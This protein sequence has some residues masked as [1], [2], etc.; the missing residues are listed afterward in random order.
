MKKSKQAFT[1]LKRFCLRLK[2]TPVLVT[3]M[4]LISSVAFA[5]STSAVRGDV[6]D[7]N[8]KPVAAASVSLYREIDNVLVKA[9]FTNPQ[10]IYSFDGIKANTYLLKITSTG[11]RQATVSIQVTGEGDIKV[12]A[13]I[14]RIEEKKLAGVTVQAQKPLFENKA[15]KIVVNVSASP[16]NAGANALEVLE[17]SPG[18][19]VDKDGNISLK[20]KAGVQVF[21]DGKPAYL[22]G[23]DL[24]NFLKNLQGT[25]L[26]QVE[27][28]TNPSARFDAA[29]NSGIINI[30]TKKTI[31]LGYS[32]TFTA[33][34][35]QGI[36]ARNNQD[37]TFNYRKNKVN[38]FGTFSRNERNT[39]RTFIIDRKFIDPTTKEV[40][41]L[42]SQESDKKNWNASNSIKLG[43][44]LFATKRTSLGILLNGYYNP[45]NSI[46]TGNINILNPNQVLQA[47]TF[48][49]STSS[50]SWKNFSSNV[51]L[52]HVFDST[53]KE[54]TADLDYV[55]YNGAH[56]QNLS[57]YFYDASGNAGGKPDTLYG[58]LPQRINIYSA[59]VDYLHP[60][61][62]GAKLEAGLK[63]AYVKT[64]ANAVYDS[65]INNTLVRDVGRSNHFIYDE[66]IYALYA[67]YSRPFTKKFSGQFGL[68]LENTEAHGNQLTTGEKFT[69]N[70]TQVFPTAFLSYKISKQ[71]SLSMNYG[72][73]IRRPDYESL[74]P[75]VKFLDR[76]TFEQGNPNLRPQF[77][78]NVEVSYSYN[79]FI[80]TTLNYTKTTNIIQVVLVQDEVT[81]QTFGRQSNIASQQQYG[82]AVN[83]F[84]QVKSFNANLFVNVYNNRFSGLLNNTNVTIGAT[85]AVLNG[86]MSYKFKKGITTEI[87]AF[88]RT[89]GIEGIFRIQP[90]GALNFGASMPLFN[91]K[92]T[93]RLGI[94]DI[95]WT[96]KAQGEVK[97]GTI[98]TRFRQVP[99]SRTISLNFSYQ[100]SKGKPATSKR[101]P[102]SAGDEQGRVKGNE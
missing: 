92:A 54:L 61:K 2:I 89:A 60:M 75:F 51:N 73:R 85:T 45:E 9:A 33:G 43:A 57:N 23:Q 24:V 97:F 68:R 21:M 25:Q 40:K 90:L 72:R 48:S 29:G 1:I 87:S 8:Q 26:D 11:Y 5:Q 95:F 14:M 94:R 32:A 47:S 46:S 80:S 19:T 22:S 53:G 41:T 99:D 42:L 38:L 67:S 70:Y 55:Y 16:G 93:L 64:G 31:Q 49:R 52:R 12:P 34:Y 96:Q 4:L 17:K 83:I 76:Y 50:S 77:S 88:Y 3:A 74:N 6:M 69:R 65:L 59:K 28:M 79:N 37:I 44:D 39:I 20:G 56:T 100:F 36:Y 86:S 35:T 27:I 13:A 91:N 101:K 58:N 7:E 18:V 66:K 10:G 78:H 63:A 62:K 102:G 98:D 82:A 71:H 84:K 15:D 81:N 30:K